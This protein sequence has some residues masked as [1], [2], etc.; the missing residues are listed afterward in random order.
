MMVKK[1]FA[2]ISDEMEYRSDLAKLAKFELNA[3]KAGKGLWAELDDNFREEVD[4]E[5]SEN[6]IKETEFM[7]ELKNSMNEE[8][9]GEEDAMESGEEENDYN[10][11]PE[12][13]LEDLIDELANEFDEACESI[14][15]K[16]KELDNKLDEAGSSADVG[17]FRLASRNSKER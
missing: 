11:D 1:G 14:E 5:T 13:G 15:N 3:Q 6:F 16:I 2:E 10:D 4:N 8:K 7:E 12:D 17:P 9:I